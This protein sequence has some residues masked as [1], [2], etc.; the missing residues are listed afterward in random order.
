[1][2]APRTLRRIGRLTLAGRRR[3]HRVDLRHLVAEVVDDLHRDLARPRRVER[4]ARGAVELRPLPLVDLG[5]Q[6]L[7]QLLVGAV[8]RVLA[9]G[10]EVVLPDEEAL[11]VVVGVDE[12]AGDV[13]HV[14]GPHHTGAV[15]EHVH[16]ENR[17]HHLPVLRLQ[18]SVRLAE[19]GEQVAGPGPLQQLLAGAVANMARSV[20]MRTG[21]NRRLPN[22]ISFFN[23][24][25]FSWT[26]PSNANAHTSG[27]SHPLPATRHAVR[28]V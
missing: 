7:P 26:L 9:A 16:P 22:L 23:S 28:P 25:V 13:V 2:A 3:R 12:P 10:E 11:S 14:T 15:V 17:D 20:F 27:T 19:D 4:L 24:A 21:S 1:M 6:R 18:L 5:P 8:L